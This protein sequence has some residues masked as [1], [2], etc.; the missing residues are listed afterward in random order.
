MNRARLCLI[1]ACTI[2]L[3]A[4]TP[5]PHPPPSNVAVTP[6]TPSITP[7]A[8]AVAP[9]TVVLTVGDEK[10]TAGE[11]DQLIEALQIHSAKKRE[12]AT[13]LVEIKVMYQEAHKRKL[14]ENP[15]VQRELEV[16]RE[17][18]LARILLQDMTANAQVDDATAQQY[19]DRHKAD[20]ET[21]HARHILIR[22]KGSSLPV[23]PGKKELSD[24][25]GLA[26]AQDIRK[27]L[28]AGEDFAALAKAESDDVQSGAKG[29]DLGVVRHNQTVPPFDQAVFSLPVGQLSEPIKTQFGYHIIKV[30]QRD[31]KPFAEVKVD[32]I[33]KLRPELAHSAMENLQKQATVVMDD[34]YFGPAT[35]PPAPSAR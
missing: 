26:K 25:E 15:N 35:T 30:E 6:G 16:Q 19:Y 11:F 28:L 5:T 18:F 34:A 17:S 23:Q 22:V 13:R 2:G 31:V 32:V 9:N 3:W 7:S 8:P 27:K 4:Q 24:E 10:I 12:I 33:K 21:V 1:F 20:Y 14:D 29:G